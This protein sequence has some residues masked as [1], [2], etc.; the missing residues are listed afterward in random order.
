MGVKFEVID[1][2]INEMLIVSMQDDF[3]VVICVL[4]CVFI[5]GCYVIFFWNF[6]VGCIVYD[7]IMKF[8]ID[9][10]IYGDGV[11]WMF[12]IWWYEE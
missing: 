9:F 4:D 10:L 3:V 11:D 1:G 8:F 6:I 7:K 12:V 2:L 5:V